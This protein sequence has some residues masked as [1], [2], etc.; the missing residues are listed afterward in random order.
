MATT[1]TYAL[2]YFGFCLM[3]GGIKGYLGGAFALPYLLTASV[4]SIIIGFL[5]RGAGRPG[6]PP[7]GEMAKMVIASVVAIAF[8]VFAARTSAA[9]AKKEAAKPPAAEQ[10]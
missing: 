1:L 7:S 6:R 9:I 8:F 5:M 10:K 2:L 4:A 3:M